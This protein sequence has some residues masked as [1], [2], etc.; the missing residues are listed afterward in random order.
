[1]SKASFTV[2]KNTNPD[3]AMLTN[4]KSKGWLKHPNNYFCNLMIA[5]ESELDKLLN[6]IN[7]F[8]EVV[9]GFIEKFGSFVIPCEE[10]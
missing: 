6:N 10:H 3:D 9:D 8:K 2:S 1:M 4:I 7:V 5:V